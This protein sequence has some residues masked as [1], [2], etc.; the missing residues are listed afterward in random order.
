MQRDRTVPLGRSDQT[1][2]RIGERAAS[3]GCAAC[4]L[5]VSRALADGVADGRSILRAM[6]EAG[7]YDDNWR[8]ADLFGSPN[9]SKL[10]ALAR[11]GLVES[12]CREQSWDLSRK[13][14]VVW[15][16]TKT[17]KAAGGG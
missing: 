14:D 5:E 11:R 2:M 3:T 6:H 13:Y 17:G 9:G 15:T 16:L 10:A 8:F 7:A 4:L 1:L 12:K